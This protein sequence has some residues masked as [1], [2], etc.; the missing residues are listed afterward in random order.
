MIRDLVVD[1]LN[2]EA[3]DQA[4]DIG[5]LPAGAGQAWSAAGLSNRRAAF[6]RSVWRISVACTVSGLPTSGGLIY[7]LS[8]DAIR[9]ALR[10]TAFTGSGGAP[11]DKLDCIS[12]LVS[13][14][15]SSPTTSDGTL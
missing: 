15:H 11:T 2:A 7:S 3:V 13:S 14:E 8:V 4:V 10:R 6:L 12:S 1:G 5:K 9:Q